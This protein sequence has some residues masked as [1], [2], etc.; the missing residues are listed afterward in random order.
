[1]HVENGTRFLSDGILSL[2]E[3]NCVRTEYVNYKA[4]HIKYDG[5]HCYL[6]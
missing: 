4:P 5:F 2:T 3:S 1:M 6:A